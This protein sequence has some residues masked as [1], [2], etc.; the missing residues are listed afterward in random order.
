MRIISKF[1]DYYDSVM[2]HGQ[3][4][5]CLY[6]RRTNIFDLEK[7]KNVPPLIKDISAIFNARPTENRRGM[8]RKDIDSIG[9]VHTRHNTYKWD[10]I[11]ILFCGKLYKGISISKQA[12]WDACNP[13]DYLKGEVSY[14]YS[15]KAVESYMIKEGIKNKIINPW[16]RRRSVNIT[17]SV[18]EYFSDVKQPDINWM[19]VNKVICVVQDGSVITVNPPLRDVQFYKVLGAYTAFQELDM[20]ISGT[21]AYPQNEMLEISD[22]YKILSHGFDEKYGF[23]TRPKIKL[24]NQGEQ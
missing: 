1:H 15:V 11:S 7:D 20:W 18:D 3:D 23:R 24:N 22:V 9:T 6:L 12:Q 14:F 5:S 8:F 19:I 4:E 16:W 21:L 10:P 2:G 17:K 13:S